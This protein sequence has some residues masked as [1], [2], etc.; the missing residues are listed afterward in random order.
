MLTVYKKVFAKRNYEEEIK[1]HFSW[2]L[3]YIYTYKVPEKIIA[4]RY[5]DFFFYLFQ[6]F[7]FYKNI[8][9]VHKKHPYAC[10]WFVQLRK[11]FRKI[12]HFL[13]SVLKKVAQNSR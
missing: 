7:L 10:L 9:V 11:N 8:L 1:W 5:I 3:M 2:K 13:I 4:S 12:S 6:L